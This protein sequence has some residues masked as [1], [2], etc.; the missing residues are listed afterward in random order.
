MQCLFVFVRLPGIRGHSDHNRLDHR[1]AFVAEG[2]AKNRFGSSGCS[3]GE[4]S[5]PQASAILQSQSL[6]FH[7]VF[8][9]ALGK[10]LLPFN[11]VPAHC[12]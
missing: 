11:L 1:K 8:G 2:L 3:M 6:Q 9:I 4:P 7:A 10:H 12:S 5:A